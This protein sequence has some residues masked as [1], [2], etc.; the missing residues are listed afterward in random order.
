M[1]FLVHGPGALP[2][3]GNEAAPSA[4]MMFSVEVLGVVPG[5]EMTISRLV[6]SFILAPKMR[7]RAK[8]E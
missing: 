2:Q 5:L 7:M 6:N 3:A 8:R 1:I 4:L